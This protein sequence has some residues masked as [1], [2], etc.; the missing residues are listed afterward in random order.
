MRLGWA[1]TLAERQ[2]A[3]IYDL[4]YSLTNS[5]TIVKFQP[6][7]FFARFAFLPTTSGSSIETSCLE[8]ESLAGTLFYEYR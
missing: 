8:C 6:I 2:P 3:Q 5:L 1:A 7:S 4:K